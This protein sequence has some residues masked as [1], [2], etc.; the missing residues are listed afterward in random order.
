MRLLGSGRQYK[1]TSDNG[2]VLHIVKYKTSHLEEI[3]R[4]TNCAELDVE[5][6]SGERV[7]N[8]IL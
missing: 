4:V 8:A 3:E 6:L 2:K 5:K 7:K 1:I